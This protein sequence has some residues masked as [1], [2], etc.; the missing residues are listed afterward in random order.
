MEATANVMVRPLTEV[1]HEVKVQTQ[2]RSDLT[3]MHHQELAVVETRS[4]VLDGEKLNCEQIPNA[5]SR[6]RNKPARR[7]NGDFGNSI[8]ASDYSGCRPKR[9][10]EKP[11]FD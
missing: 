5:G 2:R 7:A 8:D 4:K 10:H 11:W 1:L 3:S 6:I 9:K